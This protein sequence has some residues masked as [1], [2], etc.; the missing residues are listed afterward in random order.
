MDDL[1]AA[2]KNKSCLVAGKNLVSIREVPGHYA[3]YLCFPYEKERNFAVYEVVI[4]AEQRY[5]SG[6]HG[7]KTTEYISVI[8]GRLTVRCGEESSDILPGD[9]F[10]FASDKEHEYRGSGS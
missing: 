3:V 10:C 8:R 1:L 9:L 5:R 6:S 2:A 4:E 7:E